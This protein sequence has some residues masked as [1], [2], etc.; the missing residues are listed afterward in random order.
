MQWKI[1]NN[2]SMMSGE[3]IMKSIA[4]HTASYQEKLVNLVLLI[5]ERLLKY[6]GVL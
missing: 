4:E 1:I 3:E 6:C 2:A 5:K